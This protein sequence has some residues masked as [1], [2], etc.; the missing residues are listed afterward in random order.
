MSRNSAE[1]QYIYVR[2][3]TNTDS[4]KQAFWPYRIA[5]Y[6]FNVH[7]IA[8]FIYL[9]APWDIAILYHISRLKVSSR[10]LIW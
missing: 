4:A 5:R 3:T 6:L 2:Q 7:E 10:A 8:S 9:G 1:I